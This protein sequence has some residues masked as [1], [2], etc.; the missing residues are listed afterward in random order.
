ML[1]FANL[2]YIV[3]ILNKTVFLDIKIKILSHRKIVRQCY[4]LKTLERKDKILGFVIQNKFVP[5]VL[6]S[7][8][9]NITFKHSKICLVVGYFVI[10]GFCCIWFHFFCYHD[11]L[12]TC[13]LEVAFSSVFKTFFEG[14]NILRN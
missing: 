6:I 4:K 8:I 2:N 9:H 1:I 3:F 13:Y 7:K 14:E 10:T 12:Y 5:Q 11:S